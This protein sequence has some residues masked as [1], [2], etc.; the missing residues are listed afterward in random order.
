VRVDDVVHGRS[1]LEGMEVV[2]EIVVGGVGTWEGREYKKRNIVNK[3]QQH[4]R[5][6]SM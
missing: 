4:S 3:G 1:G 5:E 6:G 2:V